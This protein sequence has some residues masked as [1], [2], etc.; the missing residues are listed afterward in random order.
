MSLKQNRDE[1]RDQLK[2]SNSTGP[3]RWIELT[4]HWN[5][6]FDWFNKVLFPY[7]NFRYVVTVFFLVSN[8]WVACRIAIQ[9]DQ[10]SSLRIYLFRFIFGSFPR[11]EPFMI[12]KSQEYFVGLITLLENVNSMRVFVVVVVVVVT[13]QLPPDG[14]KRRMIS[15][16]CV[17]LMETK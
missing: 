8:D 10:P 7:L 6:A 5:V 9:Y 12:I 15:F 13:N 1:S 4:K 3:N 11:I 17:A 14:E 2:R 16:N